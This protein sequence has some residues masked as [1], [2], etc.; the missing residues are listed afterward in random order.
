MN[1]FDLKE[2]IIF[3]I[4]FTLVNTSDIAK[5]QFI[6]MSLFLKFQGL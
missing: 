3:L 4:S 2:F 5:D 6:V 1:F